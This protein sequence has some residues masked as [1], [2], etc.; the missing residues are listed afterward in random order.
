MLRRK[1]CELERL[2]RVVR[3]HTQQIGE[4]MS[5]QENLD[6]RADRLATQFGE[7]KS[8]VADLKAQIAAGTPAENLDFTKLDAA[9]GSV[10]DEV[11]DPPAA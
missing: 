2:I 9:I 1:D 5:N 3:R 4:L 6:A 11:P 7:V 8:E 10:A